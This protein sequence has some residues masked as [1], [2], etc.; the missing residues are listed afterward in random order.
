MKITWTDEQREIPNIGVMEPGKAY[1][2]P[3]DIGKSLIKQGQAVK[4]KKA[5]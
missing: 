3:N 1:I 4:Y 5:K 2:V